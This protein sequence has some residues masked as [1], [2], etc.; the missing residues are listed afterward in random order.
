MPDLPEAGGQANPRAKPRLALRVGVT[1]ARI[2]HADRITDLVAKTRAA[3]E[4][5]R[6]EMAA[7][8]KDPAVARRYGFENGQLQPP[9]LR[10]V[11]PLALGADRLVATEAVK[12]D[13]ALYVP[14]PFTHGEYEQD[15]A[16]TVPL[17]NPK[18]LPITEAEDKKQF[19][20]L[21]D[22]AG[23]DW[24]SLDGDYDE[25]KEGEHG[26]TRKRA[27]EAVGHFVVRNSDI[28]I[29]IWD[30]EP[31]AGRGG[32]QE[33]VH[34]AAKVGVPIWWIH[35]TANIAPVWI[36]DIQDLRDPSAAPKAADKI[37]VHLRQQILPPKAVSRNHWAG[38]FGLSR[39]GVAEKVDP[40][41]D[42]FNERPRPAR[43]IWRLYNWMMRVTSG[44]KPPWTKPRKPPGDP[45]AYW[46]RLYEPA[47]ARAAEYAAR[48]R[49]SYVWI[50]ILT[51]SSV[52]LGAAAS[53]LHGQMHGEAEIWIKFGI[54]FFAAA[55]VACIWT[56]LSFVAR[57]LRGYWHERSIEYRLLA[58]LCR[59][60]QVLAPLGRAI[61]FGAVQRLSVL[62]EDSEE[63]VLLDAPSR[64][65]R[66]KR[67][68]DR[69]GWVNWLF[70]AYQRAAP[71]PRGNL[72]DFLSDVLNKDVLQDLV[73]EQVEYHEGR[74]AMAS[75]A[76]EFFEK[77]G[78]RIFFFV[79]LAVGLK[80]GLT[81]LTSAPF[82]GAIDVTTAVL[83][84]LGVALP[85]ISAAS[86]GIG[87]YAEWQLLAEES[88]HMLDLL[89]LAQKRITRL[90]LHR[91]LASQD[92]GDEA[93]TVASLMLQDLEGW[94]RLFRVKIIEAQ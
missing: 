85:A 5:I 65:H 14:M 21:F 15:F 93:D 23:P 84:F 70:K 81:P 71:L 74:A 76:A 54:M 57:A 9:L 83:G 78:R 34:Y 32:T 6:D 55:E 12:L 73:N 82:G 91:P 56:T 80:I 64:P 20:E 7:L 29:A 42:Y 50:F 22:Q 10:I 26:E 79:L 45:A 24:M 44:C 48:Y 19:K 8:A 63:A 66:P 52:V 27:Y 33:I 89:K 59:K 49:S 41:E 25:E 46:F 72:A 92:L 16:G 30:G 28:L 43:D 38:L 77:W 69:T 11:S 60:Q 90:D 75:G 94:Q 4:R 58:E 47:D 18:A 87:S 61:S 37:K 13:Y 88:N 68:P 17:K 53:A 2:L 1:G 62:T 86:V 3:L 67:E 39:F 31:A 35:A 51:T 36:A 40:A